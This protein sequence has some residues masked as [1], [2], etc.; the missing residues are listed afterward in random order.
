MKRYEALA[1]DIEASI[2]NGTLKTGDRLPSVRHTGASR[3]VSASTVFEAYYLL[4]ARGLVRARDRSG[5]YV[6]G[7]GLRDAPP[8]STLISQPAIA[9]VRPEV[10][11]LVFSILEAPV[12][13]ADVVPLGSA[14]PSP[15]LY[16][17]E[18]LARTLARG[19]AVDFDPWSTVDDGIGARQHRA[20]PPHHA[21]LPRRRGAA[22][23]RWRDHP[24]QRRPRSAEPVPAGA[25]AGR[26]TP[27]SS[28][29]P[30]FYGALQALE[31][32]GL[33]A[34][35][36]PTCATRR[37]QTCRCWNRALAMYRPQAQACAFH[38]MPFRKAARYEPVRS[39]TAPTSSRPAPCRTASPSARS[40]PVR[41]PATAGS[42]AGR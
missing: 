12:D 26:G 16:P 42:A 25:D 13:P 4:E 38:A 9:S 23:A 1:A 8:E 21:A 30:S 28:S 11:D 33:Q 2:R 17:L 41:R 35:E 15:L 19:A 18:R 32:C 31:R 39:N 14:F 24:D 3:G 7:G 34:I 6:T 22:A 36:V 29:R 27:W 5:Y 20:A 10:D 40:R 37:H